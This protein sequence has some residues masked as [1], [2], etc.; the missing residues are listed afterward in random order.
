MVSSDRIAQRLLFPG[1]RPGRS[2]VAIIMRIKE[3]EVAWFFA[4]ATHEG[5]ARCALQDRREQN[6]YVYS[7]AIR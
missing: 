5:A 7:Q 6:L 2:A 4:L 1:T 3:R